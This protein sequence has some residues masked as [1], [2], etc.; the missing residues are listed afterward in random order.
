M[1]FNHDKN[2]HGDTVNRKRP[3][4]TAKERDGHIIRSIALTQMFCDCQK[5][6]AVIIEYDVDI[7]GSSLGADVFA[8]TDTFETALYPK[9]AAAV[10]G[11]VV[12]SERN[13]TAIYANTAPEKTSTPAER[14][15]FVVIE[16]SPDDEAAPTIYLTGY[17]RNCRAHAKT[18]KLITEQLSPLISSSGESIEPGALIYNTK[19]INLVVD[20]F[21]EG[22]FEGIKYNLYIPKG[23]DGKKKFPLLNFI[24]DGWGIGPDCKTALTQGYG[25]TIW[26][27]PNEQAKRECFVLSP[28]FPGPTIVEDDFTATDEVEIAKRLIDFIVE[29][30][31][32]DKNRI[33]HTGQSMGYLS[34][35]ELN[36]RYP[37]L[38]AGSLLV[39]G[40][41]NPKTMTALKD[42]NIWFLICQGDG[43][44]FSAMDEAI[45]NLEEVGADVGRYSWDAKEGVDAIDKNVREAISEGHKIK[46]SVFKA[47][48]VQ[49]ATQPFGDHR[50]T[51]LFCYQL[52]SLR[53]WLFS[54][55]KDD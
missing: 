15:R 27:F 40:F 39:A 23:Y 37:D 49:E 19:T 11:G 20:D 3:F 36:I 35:C 46:Y 33:Y 2:E 44:A 6:T 55:K 42:K 38:F 25:G 4:F 9:A 54:N 34:G 5:A 12:N 21:I 14:G 18:L 45:N 43:H 17:H 22:E 48:S 26:A 8:V 47:G 51:W 13:I 1:P 10:N 7:K 30:Y 50:A 16:L 53:E 29:K 52:E 41:W 31:G 24:S 32:I 28:Q